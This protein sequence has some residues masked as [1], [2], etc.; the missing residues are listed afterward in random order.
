MKEVRIRSAIGGLLFLGLVGAGIA[1]AEETD[2]L[3]TLTAEE[4]TRLAQQK[5]G[6]ELKKQ[7]DSLVQKLVSQEQVKPEAIALLT[8]HTRENS[9]LA[10]IGEIGGVKISDKFQDREGALLHSSISGFKGLESDVVILLDIDPEDVRCSVNAR[11]VGAS[12]A[13]SY[14]YVFTLGDWMQGAP[15]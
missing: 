13:R 14:L 1:R 7:L 15:A 12:R 6:R 11:Y 10:E 8:P 4:A 5:S 3:K 9:C 2:R